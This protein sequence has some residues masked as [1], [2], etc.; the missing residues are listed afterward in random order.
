MCSEPSSGAYTSPPYIREE[1]VSVDE[2]HV[3]KRCVLL[4]APGDFIVVVRSLERLGFQD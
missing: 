4:L 3:N 2:S 1:P